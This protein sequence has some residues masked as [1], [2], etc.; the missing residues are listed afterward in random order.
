MVSTYSGD[1]T[2]HPVPRVK[3]TVKSVETSRTPVRLLPCHTE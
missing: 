2:I 3:A 1:R